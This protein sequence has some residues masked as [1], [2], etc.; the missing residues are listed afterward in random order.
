VTT[1]YEITQAG[2]VVTD[3][4][5][6]ICKVGGEACLDLYIE[7]LLAK[8]KSRDNFELFIYTIDGVS[9]TYRVGLDKTAKVTLEDGTVICETGGSKCLDEYIDDYLASLSPDIELQYTYT[10]DGVA[11]TYT[12]NAEGKVTD[13]KGR[14]VCKTGG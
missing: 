9:T 6:E 13:D 1:T 8:A 2:R 5:K 3:E 4:G 7:D 14:V 12:V 11:T 10:V